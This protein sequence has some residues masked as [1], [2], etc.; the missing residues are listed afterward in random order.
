M[1]RLLRSWRICGREKLIKVEEIMHYDVDEMIDVYRLQ[2]IK[3]KSAKDSIAE[4]IRRQALLVKAIMVKEGFNDYK[5][6]IEYIN[7]KIK[8]K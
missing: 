3:I 5:K 6:T 8:E 2:Q 1:I 7:S 4:S